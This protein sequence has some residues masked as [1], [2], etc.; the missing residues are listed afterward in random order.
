MIEK[1]ELGLYQCFQCHIKFELLEL[2]VAHRDQAT[3]VADQYPMCPNC[4]QRRNLSFIAKG[5][6]YVEGH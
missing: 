6:Y 3:T 1:W 4:R 5:G 2:P